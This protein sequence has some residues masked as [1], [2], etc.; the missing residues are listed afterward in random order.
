MTLGVLPPRFSKA[1]MT[2]VSCCCFNIISKPVIIKEDRE[3]GKLSFRLAM[4][5]A[6]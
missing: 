4:G 3:N 2:G 1:H 6:L 5:Y